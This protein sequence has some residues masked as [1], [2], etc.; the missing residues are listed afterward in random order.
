[1][2]APC[3][4]CGDLALSTE[5]HAEPP[6]ANVCVCVCVCVCMCLHIVIASLGIIAFLIKNDHFHLSKCNILIIL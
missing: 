4:V 2:V 1:M 6:V 5:A 3:G